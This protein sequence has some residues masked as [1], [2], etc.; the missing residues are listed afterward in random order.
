M[1][2]KDIFTL[3]NFMSLFRILLIPIYVYIYLNADTQLDY[4]LAGGLLII[5]SLTDMFDGIVARK[6]NMISKLGKILDPIADKI[7]QGTLMICLSIY[8]PNMRTLL[9]FFIIKEGFMAV[10]G[11]ITIAKGKMLRGAKMSGKIC[12]TVLFVCMILLILFPQMPANCVNSLIIIS[13]FFMI[14]S[15]VSYISLYFTHSDELD[16]IGGDDRCR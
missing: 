8:Y 1:N 6:F 12:T 4:C 5:S 7:T 11:I 13:G 9:T 15:L 10:M 3:P 16:N 14:V 2:K